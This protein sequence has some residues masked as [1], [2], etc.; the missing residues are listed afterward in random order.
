VYFDVEI[1]VFCL[2]NVD[3]S[4][5]APSGLQLA[6]QTFYDASGVEIVKKRY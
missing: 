1:K 4:H 2:H 6:N 5:S 3:A